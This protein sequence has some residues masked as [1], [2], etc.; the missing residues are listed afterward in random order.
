MNILAARQREYPGSSITIEE[1][2]EPGANYYRYIAWYKSDGLRIYGLLT[3][4]FGEM[5]ASGWPAIVFNHGYIDP[6]F[7]GRQSGMCIC[8]QPGK[9]WIHR[10]QD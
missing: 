6:Q 4:P 2:L 5:P 7:T 10:V 8:G 1:T 3:V 9:P